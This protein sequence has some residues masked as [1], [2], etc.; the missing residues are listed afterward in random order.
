MEI[1]F[2]KHWLNPKLGKGDGPIKSSYGDHL[3]IL[4]NSSDSKKLD[5]EEAKSFVITDFFSRKK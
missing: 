1:N 4:I 5:F 3:V 2:L